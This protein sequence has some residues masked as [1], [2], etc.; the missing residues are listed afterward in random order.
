M[1]TLGARGFTLVEMIVAMVIVSVIGAFIGVYV[2]PM[3]T[4]Y[5]ATQGRAELADQADLAIR[6]MQADV[7]RAVPNSIRAPGSSCVEL[8]PAKG[9]GRYRMGPDVSADTP[10]GCA[11]GSSSTCSAWVDTSDV[12][13]MFD[14]LNLTGEPPEANDW[15]VIGNQNGNDVYEGLN[16]AQVS[17]TATPL[18]SQGQLRVSVGSTQFQPGY[19]EGRFQTVA[20]GEPAVAYA[21]VG[22]DGTLNSQGDGK[23]TLIRVVRPFSA[24]YPTEA[25]CATTTDA[26]QVSTVAR[27]V[28]RCSFLYDPNAGATQQSGFVWLELE[29]SRQSERAS[30]AMGAHVSNVP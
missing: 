13:T 25:A 20:V 24:A 19:A 15:V 29:L 6:G 10:A 23:G 5:L 17:A 14:V 28:V 9:G 21:C 7:R 16:R 1:M 26:L 30:M 27:R 8:V 12:T 4:S 2:R 18:S 22:A 3:L 11:S